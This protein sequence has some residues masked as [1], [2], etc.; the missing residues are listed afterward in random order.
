[1]AVR[2]AAPRR[3]TGNA[4]GPAAARRAGTV[5]WEWEALR[6]CPVLW[7]L[8]SWRVRDIR[9]KPGTLSVHATGRAMDLGYRKLNTEAI[10]NR[11][12]IA[13][14]F[15]RTVII[16][17]DTLGVEAVLDYFPKPY[18]RGWKCDRRTWTR[19]TKPTIAGAPGGTWFHVEIS[20][21]FADDPER[22]ARAFNRVF[23]ELPPRK[24]RAR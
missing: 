1:M 22:V 24:T 18:G 10:G 20:P 21:T 23:G 19:Y 7:S 14:D 4:D 8:G 15:I 5:L 16:H 6:R 12:K 9:G 3:Y 11:R 2:K 13:L 17:A